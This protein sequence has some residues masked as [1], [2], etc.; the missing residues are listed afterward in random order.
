MKTLLLIFQLLSLITF[1]PFKTTGQLIPQSQ[2]ISMSLVTDLSVILIVEV[3]VDG[4]IEI[5]NMLV[6]LNK[7]H[8][9]LEITD[10]ESYL[11]QN[12]SELGELIWEKTIYCKTRFILPFLN[13]VQP[14]NIKG[15]TKLLNFKDPNNLELK[16]E[17]I[18]VEGINKPIIYSHLI[19][20]LHLL[21]III[22][23][24]M[25]LV[26]RN[27]ISS[28]WAKMII[29]CPVIGP[30]S[31]GFQSMLEHRIHKTSKAE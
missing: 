24:A 14:I 13:H 20:E 8:H 26:Q 18:R 5:D 31:F 21:L 3:T 22:S 28:F 29:L 11:K 23:L 7:F 12:Q 19:L 2:D 25:I 4:N 9:N 6:N 1:Q 27:K 10:K 16:S 30:I 15:K 17:I